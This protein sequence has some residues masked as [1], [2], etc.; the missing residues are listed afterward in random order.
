MPINPFL[1][2]GLMH[3]S[4]LLCVC[5]GGGGESVEWYFIFY[6]ILHRN[7]CKQTVLTLIRRRVM[8]RLNWVFDVCIIPKGSFWSKKRLDPINITIVD[9]EY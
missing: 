9:D 6:C 5:G 4:F 8:R 2:D 7:S 3:P 1:I